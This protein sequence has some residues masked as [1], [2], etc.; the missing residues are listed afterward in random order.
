MTGEW[1]QCPNLS[2]MQRSMVATA[3]SIKGRTGKYRPSERTQP[4]GH[5]WS[6]RREEKPG[7]IRRDRDC[8]AKKGIEKR[9]D[10]KKTMWHNAIH[11]KPHVVV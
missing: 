8:V 4:G 11:A 6:A 3:V 9:E 10:G 2:E 1:S 7:R 5:S